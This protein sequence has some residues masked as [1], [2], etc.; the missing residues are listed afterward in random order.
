MV[1]LGDKK[2][3]QSKH[4]TCPS[5][6]IF[7][8]TFIH[9]HERLF[10]VPGALIRCAPEVSFAAHLFRS[11]VSGDG[12]CTNVEWRRLL[13]YHV[14]VLLVEV[15]IFHSHYRWWHASCQICFQKDLQWDKK[16]VCQIFF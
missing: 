4:S 9:S 2:D 7:F 16:L 6:N 13:E 5:N 3:A 8:S 11:H 10:G 1:G 14:T 12:A 15:I